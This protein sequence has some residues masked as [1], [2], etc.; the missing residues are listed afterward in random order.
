M[1]QTHTLHGSFARSLVLLVACPTDNKYWL[2]HIVCTGKSLYIFSCLCIHQYMDTI[3]HTQTLTPLCLVFTLY[4]I[5]RHYHLMVRPTTKKQ[6]VWFVSIL[7]P[8]YIYIHLYPIYCMRARN[9]Y[10]FPYCI[11]RTV[12]H[13]SSVSNTHCRLPTTHLRL[14]CITEITVNIITPTIP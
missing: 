13:D 10:P 7:R 14:Q 6:R 1:Q 3:T 11:L 5:E 12:M 9:M 4:H 2:M 8:A